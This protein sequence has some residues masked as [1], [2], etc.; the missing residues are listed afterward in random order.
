MSEGT[1][2]R[3]GL[4]VMP[5]SLIMAP[6]VLRELG[7]STEANTMLA[8]ATGPFRCIAC[9]SLGQIGRGIPASVIL[10][11]V[12]NG[13]GQTRKIQ[14]AHPHCADSGIRVV[15]AVMPGDRYRA[16][17]GAAW[18]R[19]AD[20]DPPAVLVIARRAA[21]PDTDQS[22][23]LTGIFLSRLVEHGFAPLADPDMPLPHVH[24]LTAWH[25]LGRLAIHD[26]Y[27]GVVWDGRLPSSH[28][29]TYAALRSNRLGVVVA[30]GVHLASADQ[31]R[32]L[33][34]AITGSRAVGAAIRLADPTAASNRRRSYAVRGYPAGASGVAGAA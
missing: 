22:E 34:T 24:G 23:E 29:W 33:Y 1:E 14:F 4:I 5:H 15:R 7:G 13:S 17:P 3:E 12:R 8:N 25:T 6:E 2:K 9:G 31:A 32:D 18:L 27:G 19:P 21:E 16:L 10:L 30:S 28:A 11:L 20:T 26:R